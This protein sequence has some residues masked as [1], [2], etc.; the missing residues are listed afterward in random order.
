MTKKWRFGR[1][2]EDSRSEVISLF[3]RIFEVHNRFSLISLFYEELR[4]QRVVGKYLRS[5]MFCKLQNKG[6]P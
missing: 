4:N 2:N 5:S 3:Q 1:E 6:D